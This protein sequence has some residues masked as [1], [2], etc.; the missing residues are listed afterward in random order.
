M[1][2]LLG[3][4]KGVTY[5]WDLIRNLRVGSTGYSK[6]VGLERQ[7]PSSLAEQ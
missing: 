6:E 4:G 5:P 3:I 1:Y 2:A 7:V